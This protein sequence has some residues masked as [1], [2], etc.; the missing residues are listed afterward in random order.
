M[1]KAY[2]IPPAMGKIEFNTCM[3]R[4]ESNLIT[5]HHRK[6]FD[7]KRNA[8]END[9]TLIRSAIKNRGLGL[10][11]AKVDPRLKKSIL[12]KKVTSTTPQG[13]LWET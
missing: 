8:S 10:L 2:L 12:M 1:A 7:R 4:A 11:E 5:E 3:L 6:Q 9:S 13:T